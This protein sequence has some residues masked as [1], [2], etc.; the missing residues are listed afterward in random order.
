MIRGATL[1]ARRETLGLSLAQVAHATRIPLVHLESL[2][3]ERL[4]E[5][6]AGPYAQAYT[7]AVSRYLGLDP[8]SSEDASP[9]PATPPQGAP[10]WVVRAMAGTSVVALVLLLTSLAW[11]RLRPQ[12]PAMPIATGPTHTLELTARKPTPLRVWVDGVQVVDRKVKEGEQV[13][14]EA[15]DMIEVDVAATSHVRLSW[16]GAVVVPQGRID[17]PRRLRFVQDPRVPW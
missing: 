12:L 9:A 16:N 4:D 6:P 7:R 11:E 15:S 5:L 13:R 17:V 3:E 14:F 1:R 10:L 2:E 8:S